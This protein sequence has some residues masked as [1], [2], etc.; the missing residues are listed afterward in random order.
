MNKFL[1]IMAG[2]SLILLVWA[3][4]ILFNPHIVNWAMMGDDWRW[5]FYFDTHRAGL[6]NFFTIKN[7]LG[8]AHPLQQTYYIGILRNI[9]GLN[10][11]AFQLTQL[12]FKSLAALSIA[13]LVFKLTKEKIFAAFAA[14]FFIVFPSTAGS[15]WVV[16]GSNYL[17]AAFMCF[18]IYFYIQSAKNP[19]KILP[20]ALFFFLGL[21]AGPARAYTLVPIPLIV[22]LIRL[23]KRFRP[24]VSLRRLLIFYIL[25][26]VFLRST[27]DQY[28]INEMFAILSKIKQISSGQYYTF[29]LPFQMFSALFI[30]QSILKGIPTLLGFVVINLSLLILSVIVGFVVWGKKK[31]NSFIVK[32]TFFTIIL[33]LI[34][35]FLAFLHSK[36]GDLPFSDP[37]GNPYF[38]LDFNPTIFQA[39]IGGYIFI[40]GLFLALEWWKNQRENKV[41]M[42]AAFSWMWSFFL[43]LLLYMTHTW[44]AMIKFSNDRYS[45]SPAV[46]AVIFTSAIFALSFKAL[47]KKLRSKKISF[48]LFGIIMTFI[49][50]KEYKISDHLY[51]S[52][53]QLYGGETSYWQETMY[54]RFINKFGK[55]NLR[56]PIIL[57]IDDTEDIKFNAETFFNPIKWRIYYDENGKLIRDNAVGNCKVVTRD[58]VELKKFYT[59]YNRQ[60]GFKWD[61]ILCVD[62]TYST[63]AKTN[64]F[65][66][67]DKFYAYKMVNKEF[68]DIK[69]EIIAK[70]DQDIK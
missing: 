35:Y 38:R 49:A 34:F 14:F 26:F 62:P 3:I 10:Q 39:S 69:D 21:C 7:D 44:W 9:L 19:K 46:G 25:P 5:L 23:K 28:Q 57:F 54:Q 61:Y 11:E 2:V 29:S 24:F 60:K 63:S 17:I 64:I 42:V 47:E 48:L 36:T 50:Y 27:G 33:E 40:L 66:P 51:Y 20:A 41:L 22:E 68:I 53:T 1:K 45:F 4:Q 58:I 18:S 37:E 55:E 15:F 67:I 16:S 70:L 56:E 32:I 52:F 8:S 31:M 6:G 12:L 43:I 65:Y 30:D 13:F 59:S